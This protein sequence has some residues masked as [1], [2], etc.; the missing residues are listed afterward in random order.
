MKKET[1]IKQMIIDGIADLRGQDVYGCDLHNEIFNTDY[2]IIGTYEANKWLEKNVGVFNAISAIKDYER[3]NYGEVTTDFSDAEKVCNMYVYLL[4][5]EIMGNI[6]HLR[7][8][9][10]NILTD[11]DYDYI[12]EQL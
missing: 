12:L 3:E 1:Q 5:E 9:Y 2:F 11:E 7:E 8:V 6:E 4:S 10:D